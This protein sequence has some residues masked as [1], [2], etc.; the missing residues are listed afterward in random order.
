[1][2][3]HI[4]ATKGTENT[5]KSAIFNYIQQADSENP[6]PHALTALIEILN[7][8]RAESPG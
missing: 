2:D 5:G 1:M 6:E 3:N 4:S 7:Q 8:K